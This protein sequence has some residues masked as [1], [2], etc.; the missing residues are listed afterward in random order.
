VH[1][2]VIAKVATDGRVVD[3]PHFFFKIAVC[4]AMNVLRIDEEIIQ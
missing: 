2:F 1:G 3:L 4:S